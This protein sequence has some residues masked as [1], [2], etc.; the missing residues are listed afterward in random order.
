M[1]SPDKASPGSEIAREFT[2]QNKMGIHARPAAMIV[3]VANKFNEVDVWVD[4][5]DEQ[6]N[7]RSIM[8][9]MMLAA[10]Q[11]SKL[12]FIATG[13]CAED[14]LTELED[15]FTRKFEEA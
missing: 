11:G 8:G 5:D 2:V 3:R 9:L 15:L 1:Q 4:K 7:G 6:V 14:L 12:R 10:G 13:P